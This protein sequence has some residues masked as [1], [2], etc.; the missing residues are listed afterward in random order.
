M[1]LDQMDKW[2][3]ERMCYHSIPVGAVPE[4]T[5][6]Q[7][8]KFKKE[9]GTKCLKVIWRLKGIYMLNPQRAKERPNACV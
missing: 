3:F 1:V 8:P 9:L 6:H 4:I 5:I 7:K 2:N